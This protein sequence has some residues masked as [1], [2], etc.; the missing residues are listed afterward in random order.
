VADTPS[1][2]MDHREAEAILR[3]LAGQR[4]DSQPAPSASAAPHANGHTTE[5]SLSKLLGPPTPPPTLPAEVLRSLVEAVPDA[6][7]VADADG[8]IVLVNAQTVKFFGYSQEELLGQPIELLVPIPIREQHVGMRLAYS[9]DPH[10]RPMGAGLELSG[11]RKD[12]QEVPV[13][14]GLSPLQTDGGRLV[15]ASVRDVTERRKGESKLRKM[16]ARY[17]TLVEGIPAV[18]FMAA[19][20]EGAN[21]LYVSPQIEEL[22]GFTQQEWIDNPILWYAQLHP[23]DQFRWHEEFARTVATGERFRSIYRFIARDGG[24]VWVHGEAQ[25]VRDNDG[26]PLFLQGVAFDITAMKQA[27]EKLRALNATLEDRVA[28]RTKELAR[29]NEAL[30]EFGYVVAHDLRQPLRT[31]KSFIQKLAKEYQGKLDAE[32]DD[33]I[34]RTVNA[35]DRMRLLIDDLLAYARVGSDGKELAPVPCADSVR[36]ACDNLHAAMEEAGATV[37]TNDLPN[38]LAD[39]TQLAQLFQNLIGNSL[40]YRAARPP[41]IHVSANRQDRDWLIQVTDNGLGIEVEYLHK[42]FKLGVESRL[43]SASKI[44]GNGIG[45]ATCEKIVSRHGGK[46]WAASEGHDKGTTISFILRAV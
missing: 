13:E 46:I 25:V 22:L 41:E 18:T 12:G 39:P 32:A 35:A 6:L 42:I 15:V 40:K 5:P 16:E 31:M 20:D 19:M 23:D 45:L 33:H 8:R 21:E 14:I 7:I 3:R 38:V 29:S 11:R 44:P 36:A 43:H 4:L 34:K 1:P 9:A 30:G 28:A 26:R 2:I 24:V 10:I 27:E 37:T 17:R